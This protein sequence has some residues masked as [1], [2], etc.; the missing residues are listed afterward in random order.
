MTMGFMHKSPGGA[1]PCSMGI[2]N[3]QQESN[4]VSS[5]AASWHWLQHVCAACQFT[6]L[7]STA[8][9]H[10]VLSVVM[11][12]IIIGDTFSSLGTLHFGAASILAN[13]HI[14]LVTIGL[15]IILPMCFARN[16]SALGELSFGI[17]TV[18]CCAC[19]DD[20]VPKLAVS[21]SGMV[22]GHT[23]SRTAALSSVVSVDVLCMLF[24]A[25]YMQFIQPLVHD[26]GLALHV[27]G[28]Q[29]YHCLL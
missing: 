23:V 20:S 17:V 15:G 29:Q 22:T 5:Y 10:C 12:Q 27:D 24:L 16:L 2:C 4:T 6:P 13:R 9:M 14:I 11:L 3:L 25:V 28:C 8:D 26:S 1:T 21:T 18:L 19:S 7:F